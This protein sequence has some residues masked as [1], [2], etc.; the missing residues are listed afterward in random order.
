MPTSTPDWV[1]STITGEPSAAT[2]LVLDLLDGDLA[3]TA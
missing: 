3:L 1:V 2:A